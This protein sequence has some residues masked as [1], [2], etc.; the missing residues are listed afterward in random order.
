MR[1]RSILPDVIIERVG[2][3]YVVHLNAGIPRFGVGWISQSLRRVAQSLV[4]FQRG[5]L[6]QGL[7][8]LRPLTLGEVAA[9]IDMHESSVCRAIM[10][11]YVQTPRGLF[12]LKSFFHSGLETTRGATVSSVWVKEMIRDMLETEEPAAAVSDLNVAQA[13]HGHGLTI[14]RRTV[15]KY[16]RALGIPSSYQRRRA[17]PSIRR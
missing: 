14:S 16:R 17:R 8:F 11:R 15:A 4:H 10:N 6:D 12:A 3:D 1:A 9:D 5:F 13:L 2:N 7:P